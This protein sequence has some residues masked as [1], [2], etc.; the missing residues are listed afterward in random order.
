[1]RGITEYVVEDLY[2]YMERHDE[3]EFSVK[4]CA[5]E[6]YNEAVRDLLTSESDSTPLRLLDDPER[7]TVV[8][9]LTEEIVIDMDH[10]QELLSIC[11][12]QRQIGETSL[13]ETSSRSHQLLRLTI[14]SSAREY[15]GA[16][17]SSSLAA[18]VV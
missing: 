11:E 16:E 3:R 8:E 15:D 2:D 4:F 10:L 9:K 14:E 6:I 18:S 5:M 1:M 12:A 7:G 13:N 17:N